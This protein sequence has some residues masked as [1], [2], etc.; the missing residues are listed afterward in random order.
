MRNPWYSKKNHDKLY[1]NKGPLHDNSRKNPIKK[2]KKLNRVQLNMSTFLRV[3]SFDWTT[4]VEFND[5][6][7]F[8]FRFHI[9]IA[10]D[11]IQSLNCVVGQIYI[12][13]VVM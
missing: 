9:E 3:V 5:L 8:F 11:T 4:K 1:L 6:N 7:P 2:Q 12:K 10:H 13:V